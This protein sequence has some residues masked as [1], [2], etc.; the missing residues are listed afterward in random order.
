MNDEII[1]KQEERP[2]LVHN[3]DRTEKCIFHGFCDN[4]SKCIVESENGELHK[5]EIWKVQFIDNRV[6]EYA[7]PFVQNRVKELE[8]FICDVN[9]NEIASHI[10]DGTL[11]Q[12]CNS[13]KTR[14]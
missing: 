3:K 8:E 12:W 5:S 11:D 13:W 4:N 6:N 1:I 14:S 10:T 9:P 7:Y 2:C